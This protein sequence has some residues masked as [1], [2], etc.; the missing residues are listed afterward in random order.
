MTGGA[1]GLFFAATLVLSL[2][3]LLVRAWR[4]QKHR[5]E[6]ALTLAGFGALL[7]WA[8]EGL[9]DFHAASGAIPILLAALLGTAWAAGQAR[10]SQA[11]L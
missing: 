10:G 1:V 7:F 2:L 9:A 3:F 11:T 5:E 4:S 8:L 6:S